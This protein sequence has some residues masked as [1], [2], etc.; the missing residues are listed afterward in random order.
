[1][2]GD[3]QFIESLNPHS[4]VRTWEISP[5]LEF[6]DPRDGERL[7]EA[8]PTLS[9]AEEASEEANGPVFW[10]VYANLHDTVISKLMPPT[11]H[12]HDFTCHADAV[13]FVAVMNGVPGVTHAKEVE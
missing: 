2:T 9:E 1:M 5:C 13:E 11:V 8:Y 4:G 3:R 10:G 6:T 7:V 12:L